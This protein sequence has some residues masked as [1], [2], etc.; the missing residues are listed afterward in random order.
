M[1]Y[2][3]R[4]H[5][6][7]PV[8]LTLEALETRDLL[9][10]FTPQYLLT[11]ATSNAAPQYTSAPTGYA[12]SQV[13]HAYGF[14]QITFNNG[15]IKGDGSGQTIAIVDAYDDPNITSDLH[16]FDLAFGLPDPA[17]TK[18]NENGGT[19]LPAGN[20][21]WATEIALD[22]EW[23]HAIAPG[24]SILLVEADSN[25]LADLLSAVQYAANQPS[26]SVVSMSWGGSE[27][28]WE[29]DYDSVFT[30]PSGHQG[31]SFIASSGDSGAPA[32]YPAVSPNVLAVGGTSLNLNASG[33]ISES[34]W[35]DSTGGLSAY[36]SQPSYQQGVVSQGTRQRGSPDVAY[37]ANPYTGMSVY[38]SYGTPAGTPW[39]QVGGTS[40]GAPQWAAL[41]A[42]ADQGRA[43]QGQGTLDGCTQLLPFLY[44]LPATDFHDVTTG[45]SSG[46]PN[47]PA[48]PGY[49]LA[50]GRGSPDAP[51]IVAAL[52]QQASNSGPS[53]GTSGPSPT[54]APS[55]PPRTASSNPPAS[56]SPAP[57]DPFMQ[58]A[59]D[60][61]FMVR[62]WEAGNFPALLAGWNGVTSLVA[63]HPSSARQLEQAFY[64]DLFAD[65]F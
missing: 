58:L 46:S 12:P 23:A 6:S 50:T 24:A 59:A 38:D 3:P 9:S 51:L 20:T 61:V 30:T 48:G 36:E 4:S 27:F 42:I 53:G 21:A 49:D 64:A 47:Y 22:V 2:L 56:S 32:L 7:R 10:G 65:L 60:V 18:V 45:S 44:S 52:S 37:D 11:P 14:N 54:P 33:Y 16:Q 15:T 5:S 43:S 17:F 19:A 1:I 40:A 34:A 25:S 35:S 28:A 31:V 8:R 13:S 39:I 26:V 63:S 57:A 29:T 41:V 55:N 62:S